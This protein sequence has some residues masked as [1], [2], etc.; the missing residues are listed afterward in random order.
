MLR[1]LKRLLQ[2]NQAW[3]KKMTEHDPDFFINL[4]K[5]QSPEYLWIG[6]SFIII[7]KVSGFI[8]S[9]NPCVSH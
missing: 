6:F 2:K 4:S 5:Q 1:Q 9:M 8:Y 3:A 7:T